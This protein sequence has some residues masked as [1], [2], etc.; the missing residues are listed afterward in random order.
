M[1][2]DPELLS[3]REHEVLLLLARGHTNREVADRLHISVRT[4][5]WHRASIRRK[6]NITSRAG[7][8]AY[9][10]VHGLIQFDR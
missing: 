5:E 1:L 3:T 9:A 4:A 6:L 2:P 10:A 8:V 7:L